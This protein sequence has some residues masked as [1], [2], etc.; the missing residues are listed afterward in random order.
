MESVNQRQCVFFFSDT[1]TMKSCWWVHVLG[2]PWILLYRLAWERGPGL[3]HRFFFF[4]FTNLDKLLIFFF[5]FVQAFMCWYIKGFYIWRYILAKLDCFKSIDFLS[6]NF[7]NY[8]FYFKHMCV[9][10]A[11]MP[12][13]HLN[14]CCLSCR[15]RMCA[16]LIRTALTDGCKA[17]CRCWE[18]NLD[19][20]KKKQVLYHAESS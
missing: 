8:Y 17:P 13:H 12:V 18:S 6:Y 20:Q 1:G 7:L 2:T 10:P 5:N 11:C 9:L 19:L 15:S 16:W 4:F 14:S 3:A